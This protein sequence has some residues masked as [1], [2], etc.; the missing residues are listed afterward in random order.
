MHCRDAV[1]VRMFVSLSN[2]LF[3]GKV[4]FIQAVICY[5]IDD[6]SEERNAG[7]IGPTDCGESVTRRY[8]QPHDSY[9]LP[10]PHE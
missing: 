10:S 6:K 9:L 3:S 4:E 7:N 2:R 5:K 8:E 1:A